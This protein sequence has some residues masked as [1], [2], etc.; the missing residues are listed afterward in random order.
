MKENS[1]SLCQLPLF[2]I[3]YI[4]R[5][6]TYYWNNEKDAFECEAAVRPNSWIN[7]IEILPA[8]SLT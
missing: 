2:L 4:L 3:L 7:L 5:A 6:P 8:G 1:D